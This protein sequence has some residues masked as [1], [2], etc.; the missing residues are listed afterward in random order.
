MT[1]KCGWILFLVLF[2]P[3]YIETG[4][5]SHLSISF[6][7]YLSLR[8]FFNAFCLSTTMHRPVNGMFWFASLHVQTNKNGEKMLKYSLL[9]PSGHSKCYPMQFSN[10]LHSLQI[11]L[12]CSSLPLALSFSCRATRPNF[13]FSSFVCSIKSHLWRLVSFYF[14]EHISFYTYSSYAIGRPIN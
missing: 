12:L 6:S 9:Q 14:L 5:Y 10:A 13:F 4:E 7:L 2:V 3:N 11:T 8:L 1:P